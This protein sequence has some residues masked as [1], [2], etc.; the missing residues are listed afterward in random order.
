[1]SVNPYEPPMGES[2]DPKAIAEL[3]EVD[4]DGDDVVVLVAEE[5]ALLPPRCVLTGKSKDIR[6]HMAYVDASTRAVM[7]RQF[8]FSMR[9]V[10]VEYWLAED[11]AV[12]QAGRERFAQRIC[13]LAGLGILLTFA[14]VVVTTFSLP[15]STLTLEQRS[16]RDMSLSALVLASMAAFIVSGFYLAGVLHGP[17]RVVRVLGR[18]I[19]LGGASPEFLDAIDSRTASSANYSGAT[20]I[21]GSI[22][23]H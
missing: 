8:R 9:F 1:M 13:L 3:A 2:F 17:F 21:D 4:R 18:R 5:R 12:K 14:C 16:L 15:G 11:L 6:K 19:W 22:N 20:L 7:A 10:P 23:V